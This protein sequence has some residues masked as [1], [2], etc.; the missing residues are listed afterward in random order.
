MPVTTVPAPRT[1][2]RAVDPQP[3]VGVGVRS[4][5]PVGQRQQFRA[6]PLEV[7]ADRDGSAGKR[8]GGEPFSHL[9]D[10]RTGI[11]EVGLADHHQPVANPEGIQRREMLFRLWHP[12][13]GGGHDEHNRRDR[14]H[15]GQHVGHESLMARHVDE[16]QLA[17]T[18]LGPREAEVDGQ[19]P[20]LFFGQPVRPHAGEPVQQG[21]LAVVDVP[22][23]GYDEH[24]RTAATS[25]SSSSG[26][27]VRRSSRH[28]PASRR[29]TTGGLPARSATA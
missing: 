19:A 2:K 18:E 20:A 17:A 27:T 29:P 3:H 9:L 24:A 25:S 8:G 21:R 7:G 12:T 16:R 5:Q 28:R 26:A 23:G 22:G 15:A 14:A 6:H 10:G 13:L 4:R 11:G 1:V